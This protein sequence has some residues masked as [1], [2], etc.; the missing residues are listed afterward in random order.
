MIA[1][2]LHWRSETRVNPDPGLALGSAAVAGDELRDLV[3]LSLKGEG[4][5][6]DE[7]GIHESEKHLRHLLERA[8]AEPDRVARRPAGLISCADGAVD[9]HAAAPRSRG[10]G[11]RPATAH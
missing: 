7:R 11:D 1:I 2:W 8:A 3:V 5:T 6:L 9:H 10:S 4:R